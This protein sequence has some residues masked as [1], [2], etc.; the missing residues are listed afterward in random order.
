[1]PNKPP[2]E[3]TSEE[4]FFITPI[5]E[6]G[7]PLRRRVDGLVKILSPVVNEFNLKLMPSH[8]ISQPGSISKQVIERLVTNKL[9]IADLTGANGNVMYELA[10]RHTTGLPVVAI[11]EE[12][13]KL[14]FDVYN[15][16]VIPYKPD[17]LGAEDLKDPLR[18]AIIESIKLGTTDNPVFDHVKYSEIRDKINPGGPNDLILE[19]LN[20]LKSIVLR[21]QDN[22]FQPP[23]NPISEFFSIYL[24]VEGTKRGFSAF[25]NELKSVLPTYYGGIVE[26]DQPFIAIHSIDRMSG[27]SIFDLIA[28]I[29]KTVGVK[30]KILGQKNQ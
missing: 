12:G 21:K 8:H 13:T 11:C 9:V 3:K 23:K 27:D 18:N 19:Q 15:E 2:I 30:A 7:S 6:D 28:A 1:M 5:G 29:E 26:P 20:D 22:V 17:I 14:P 4:C 24:K 10:I 25:I 16:R